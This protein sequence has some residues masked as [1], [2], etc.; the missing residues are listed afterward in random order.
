[1]TVSA[2]DLVKAV[3]ELAAFDRRSVALIVQQPLGGY[4]ISVDGT[5]GGARN[6]YVISRGQLAE[7]MWEHGLH[8]EDLVDVDVAAH[9]AGAVSDFRS[10]LPGPRP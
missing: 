10:R 2:A 8:R 6:A 4:V 3:C 1:V 5:G 9:L 7:L